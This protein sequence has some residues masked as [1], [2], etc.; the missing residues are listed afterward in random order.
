MNIGVLDV[1]TSAKPILHPWM[2]GSYLSTIG[3]FTALES[4]LHNYHEWVYY[5]SEEQVTDDDRLGIVFQLQEELDKLD[6]LV[7]HNFKFDM[8]W[9]KF[10]NVDVSKLKVWDTMLA[11][12]MLSGQ[13]KEKYPL[14]KQSLSDCC[15]NWGLDVKTDVVKTYWDAGVPTHEIP[16]RILMP[17]MKNDVMIT[18]D[19][20]KKQYIELRKHPDLMKLVEVRNQCLHI[21]TDLELNGMPSDWDKAKEHVAA[22]QLELEHTNAELRSYFGRD[23]MNIDSGPELSAGL[24]GGKVKRVKHVPLIYTRNCTIKEPYQFTYKSGKKKGMT[25]TKFRNRVVKELLGKKRKV[26]YEVPIKGV[27]FT[28]ADKSECIRDGKPTGVFQ[29]NK[30]VLKTLTCNN[31]GGSTVKLKRRILE[32]LL[33]RSKISKF[34]STFVG[35]KE[36]T[37]LFHVASLNSDGRAHP[38]YNQTIASTGRLTSSNPNGQNFPRSKEDEDGF[39]NP[40]KSVFIPSRPEGLV[41]VGDLSQLEWR[42]A[43]WQSQDPV[44]MQEIFD[45]VDIHL[46]NAIKF[47]GD[48][49]YRQ[50]AKIMTFRLLYGG[51]AYAFWIDPKMPNFSK[52]RWDEIVDSYE[53]KYR[54]ITQWQ[55]NNISRVPLDHGFLYDAMGR[56]YKIPMEEHKRYPGTM[57]YKDTCIKNYPVQGMATGNIVPLAQVMMQ[58]KIDADPQAFMSSNWMG[59]VHDSMIFDT[60]PHEVKRL[61]FTCIQVFEAL[62]ARINDIWGLDF[63]LPLTGEA[64]WGPSYAA[65]TTSVKHEGGEWILKQK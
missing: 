41:F 26:E 10:I 44:A 5:H 30:D 40:L 55:Q 24:F 3:L 25:V 14:T 20:F 50:D 49:K 47:F 22:F 42:V 60:M 9:L 45:G 37:G 15:S 31:S 54:G 46:D 38:N 63:N 61:A 65:M 33:H 27:G 51:S 64:E 2:T 4:G 12:F 1:E 62:P 23:D 34:T 35:S 48:A 28:P 43:A 18:G 52:K 58:E 53:M 59:Q 19:L 32:L 57:V 36:G 39:T 21:F 8:N 29:T 13:D 17:Y 11:E 6:L 7:G 16:L 56:K